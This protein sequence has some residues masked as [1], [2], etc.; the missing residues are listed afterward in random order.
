MPSGNTYFS[1]G[2]GTW[3]GIADFGD[4]VM[5]LGPPSGGA[6][7]M[8]DYFTPY[9]QASLQTGRHDVSAGAPVL[10][11]DAAVRPAAAG[12]HGQDRH[13]VRPDQTT[14]ASTVPI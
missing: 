3:D 9:N 12:A 13:D 7:P 1:T 4:S 8:L 5:K 10:L 6:L 11:P 14:W 2:N